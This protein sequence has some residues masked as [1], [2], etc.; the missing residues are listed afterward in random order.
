M[1]THEFKPLVQEAF[2]TIIKEVTRVW[3]G[4]RVLT[5]EMVDLVVADLYGRKKNPA[6]E[7]ARMQVLELLR[8]QH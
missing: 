7:A 6:A 2:K 3:A 8:N 4:E 5:K 1:G